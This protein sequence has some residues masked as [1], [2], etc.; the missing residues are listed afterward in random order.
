[1][2]ME[3]RDLSFNYGS[4]V[5]LSDIS[6]LLDKSE[7]VCIMGPNGV[8]KSTLMYCMNRLLNTTSGHVLIDGVDVKDMPRME[9]AKHVGFV[10][11]ASYETFSTSVIDA[12]LMGRVPHMSMGGSFTEE[13]VRIAGNALIRMNA[14]SLSLRPFD[15]LS[16]GQHQKVMVA[17]GLAQET[18]ILL[19]DEPTANL[20]LKHQMR[21]MRTLRD[22]TRER[23]MMMVTI[24]HDVN[25]ICRYADRA[26]MMFEGRIHCVG[27]PADIVT[28][29]NIKKVYGVDSKIIEVEGR[30]FVIPLSDDDEL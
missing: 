30:P 28:P 15:E 2:K 18:D 3:I 1:M 13:D 9:L 22:L 8:G 12:V 14:E 4:N 17:R 26:I 6:L 20:D 24:C 11:H 5:I 10:P 27:H 25:I 19:L 7:L 21:V 23:D 16:A 29:E